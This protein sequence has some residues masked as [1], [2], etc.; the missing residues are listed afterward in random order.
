MRNTWG[1]H[2]PESTPH[3]LLLRDR[4]ELE[5][6]CEWQRSG[7]CINETSIISTGNHCKYMP[8]ERGKQIWWVFL[9]SLKRL[10][11]P[12]GYWHWTFALCAIE[13]SK[14]FYP[15]RS[16]VAASTRSQQPT[17]NMQIL[18]EAACL[19]IVSNGENSLWSYEDSVAVKANMLW[20]SS[21]ALITATLH[22]VFLL[23]TGRRWK[24]ECT[25]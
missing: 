1:W 16:D 2:E 10:Q 25:P 20:K 17:C 6:W 8:A 7:S 14:T 11:A 12:L 23:F 5:L 22:H 18:F 21:I 3:C 13:A 9:D 4:K 15:L 19:W 24:T